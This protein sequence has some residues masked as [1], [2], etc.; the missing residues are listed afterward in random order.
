MLGARP[1]AYVLAPFLVAVL[2]ATPSLLLYTRREV[3]PSLA[4]L[5]LAL[6]AGALLAQRL[7]V[8]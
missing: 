2:L 6:L 1:L 7:G 5:P 8:A 4:A 3:A